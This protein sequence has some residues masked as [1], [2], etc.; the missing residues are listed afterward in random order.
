[1]LANIT[2]ELREM[3]EQILAGIETK[4]QEELKAILD[5]NNFKFQGIK[6]GSR[7]RAYNFQPMKDRP[8]SYIEGI[9]ESLDFMPNTKC[10][11]Y[12]VRVFVN[13]HGVPYGEIFVPLEVVFM[14]FD[15]RVKVI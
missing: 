3:R 5:E 8:D 14:E 11:A 7:V 10:P 15:E 4:K 6:I 9:V 12:K 13:T 1:M 2:P